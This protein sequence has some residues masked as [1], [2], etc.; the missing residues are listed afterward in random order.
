MELNKP[1]PFVVDKSKNGKDWQIWRKE[2][3]MYLKLSQ[4]DRKFT[5]EEQSYI[6]INLMGEEAGRA[7]EKMSFDNEN[8]RDDIDILIKKFD[9]IFLNPRNEIEERYNF[10]SREKLKDESIDDYVEDL[11][12]ILKIVSMKNQ[13]NKLFFFF[14]EKSWKM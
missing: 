7:M 9:E 6:L 12:V 11:K 3:M 4:F 2:F 10:F 1:K 13:N 8:D 14:T 5:K